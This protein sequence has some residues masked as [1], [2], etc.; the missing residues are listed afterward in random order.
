M[1]YIISLYTTSL[2]TG[3]PQHYKVCDLN[4]TSTGMRASKGIHNK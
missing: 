4:I 1:R 2:G 3:V